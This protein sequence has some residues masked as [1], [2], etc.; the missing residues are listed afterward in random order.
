M[1]LSWLPPLCGVAPVKHSASRD[2]WGVFRMPHGRN[3][4][5][6][7]AALDAVAFT[8]TSLVSPLR[9]PGGKRRLLPYVARAVAALPRRPSL[10]VEPFAGGCAVSIGLLEHGFVPRIGLADADPLVASF[11]RVVFDPR[12]APRLAEQVLRVPLTLEFWTRMRR[13]TPRTT[14]GRAFQCLFLNRTSFSGIL[15]RTAGP[16]GG[17]AQS[18]AYSVASRFPRERLAQRILNLSELAPKVAYVRRQDWSRTFANPLEGTGLKDAR[19]IFFYVDPPFWTK[20]ERLY[21]CCF[22]EAQ[23]RE[24]A[25]S[26]ARLR[27]SWFLSYDLNPGVLKLYE[28]MTDIFQVHMRYTASTRSSSSKSGELL[29]SNVISARGVPGRSLAVL[30]GRVSSSYIDVDKY[31]NQR[32]MSQGDASG[33]AASSADDPE[34]TAA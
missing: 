22:D 16:V 6:K 28:G 12:L 11:W 18:G 34:E 29:F 19:R 13:A 7:L 31:P 26:L 23:H 30:Q 25:K 8:N 5:A 21:R 4:D 1:A 15:N 10:F 2:G 3:L 14:F 17:R 32:G 33:E 20:A 9:Y 24:L 27:S